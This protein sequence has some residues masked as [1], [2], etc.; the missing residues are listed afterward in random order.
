MFKYLG[1]WVDWK[2]RGNAVQLDKM[3]KK[4]EE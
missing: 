4:A 3:A 2:L 1:E